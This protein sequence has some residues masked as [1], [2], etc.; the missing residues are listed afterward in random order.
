M[1]SC[2]RMCSCV[3]VCVCMCLCVFVFMCV[4]VCVLCVHVF[5]HMCVPVCVCLC[6]CLRVC[7]CVCSHVC[8]CVC[9]CVLP[10]VMVDEAP[11]EGSTHVLP[12]P[13]R[14]L[15]PREIK[16]GASGSCSPQ[17]LPFQSCDIAHHWGLRKSLLAKEIMSS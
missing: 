9:V 16:C 11:C 8:S 14:S 2:V 4:F 13:G 6:V 12:V 10:S 15:T 7:S 1:C 17:P 3:F 5:D